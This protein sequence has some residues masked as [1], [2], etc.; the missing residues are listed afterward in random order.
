MVWLEEQG[1]SVVG[2]ELSPVAVRDF[3]VEQDRK[4]A[5]QP[6]GGLDEYSAGRIAIFEGDFFDLE[7]SMI[8]GIQHFYDRAALIALPEP[9]REVYAE[10]MLEL[11][12]SGATGLL[13]TLDYDQ[14]QMAGP[15]FAVSEAEVRRL[16]GGHFNIEKVAEEDVLYQHPHFEARG[17]TGL[18][19][20]A[21]LMR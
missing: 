9:M 6:H 5:H 12:P 14:H 21:F 2:A 8:P 20:R 7:S 16:F 13:I 19:E 18:C 3:F 4:P 10:K 11:V 17:L 1:Y 15:P